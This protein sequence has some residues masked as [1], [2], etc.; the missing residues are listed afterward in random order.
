MVPAVLPP[1][2]PAARQG[3]LLAHV[4]AV[5]VLAVPLMIATVALIPALAVCPFLGGG[6]QR[7]VIRLLA[8]LRQWAAALAGTGQPAAAAAQDL[9]RPDGQQGEIL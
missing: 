3:Q 6:R 9:F 5:L 7:L 2:L 4:L 1:G 8:S